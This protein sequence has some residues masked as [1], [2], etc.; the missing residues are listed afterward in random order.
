MVDSGARLCPCGLI[1]IDPDLHSGVRPMNGQPGRW[2]SRHS[3]RDRGAGPK[4]SFR[5]ALTV[6]TA[7]AAL[8][9]AIPALP[10]GAA[11]SGGFGGFGLTP[12]PASNGQVAPYFMMTLAAGHSAVA[13]TRISD[14]AKR[15]E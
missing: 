3:A 7:A 8:A 5:R 1:Y 6:A 14:T 9:A 13:I 12:A 2:P 11:A 4:R 10:A 15:T